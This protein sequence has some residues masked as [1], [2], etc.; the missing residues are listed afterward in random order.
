MRAWIGR[1]WAR[2][3]LV[4]AMMA[5]FYGAGPHGLSL[6]QPAIAGEVVLEG[7]RSAASGEAPLDELRSR[8][9]TL[10]GLVRGTARPDLSEEAFRVLEEQF[11]Q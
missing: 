1:G 7:A 11:Y 4:V 3:F 6:Q 2:C 5:S 10:V 8:I 9:D